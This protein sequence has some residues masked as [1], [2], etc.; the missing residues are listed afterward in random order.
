MLSSDTLRTWE[1]ASLIAFGYS[2]L[3]A[4]LLRPGLA[5][6]VRL[7]ALGASVV[8][9][10]VTAASILAPSNVVLHG[11]LLPPLLLFLFYWTTGLL[12]VAPMQ[13]VEAVFM[14]IDRVLRIRDQSSGAPQWLV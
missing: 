10:A 14:R 13:D 11:W 2:A 5:P 1:A 9:I 6:S 12:F 7:R 4:A 3:T 8:G